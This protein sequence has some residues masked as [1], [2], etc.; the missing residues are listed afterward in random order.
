MKHE[1]TCQKDFRNDMR[2]VQK[3]PRFLKKYFWDVDFKGV[4]PQ[5]H[6]VYVLRKVL[7]YGNEKSV[8]WVFKNYGRQ[9]VVDVLSHYRGYSQKTANFWAIVLDVP[10]KEV[11]CLKKHSSKEPKTLWPY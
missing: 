11:I 1:R 8:A 3:I 10:F 9:G 7:E 2:K 6:K 4:N 5:K